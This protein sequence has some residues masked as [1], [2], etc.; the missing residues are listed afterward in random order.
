MAEQRPKNTPSQ[1]SRMPRTANMTISPYQARKIRSHFRFSAKEVKQEAKTIGLTLAQLYAAL[2]LTFTADVKRAKET[3]K[4]MNKYKRQNRL[5]E[6]KFLQSLNV[7]EPTTQRSTT[8]RHA[9]R[10][11]EYYV[12]VSFTELTSYKNKNGNWSQF[13]ESPQAQYIRTVARDS[14]FKQAAID[15]VYRMYD[16]IP[17]SEKLKK[18]KEGSVKIESVR[19]NDINNPVLIQDIPMRRA[20]VLAYDF[21]PKAAD[22][23]LKTTSMECVYD[24]LMHRYGNNKRKVFTKEDMLKDFNRFNKT[25][26]QLDYKDGVTPHMLMEWC[27]K[28]KITCYMFDIKKKMFDNYIS[29]SRNYPPLMFYSVDE[30]MY[31]IEDEETLKSIANRRNQ[32][33]NNTNKH[34]TGTE[35]DEK[36]IEDLSKLKIYDYE[37]ISD[38]FTDKLDTLEAPCIIMVQ[39]CD[40]LGVFKEI[41]RYRN[42]V[43]K[44]IHKGELTIKEIQY[45]HKDGIIRIMKD[46][47][48]GTQMRYNTIMSICKHLNVPWTNQGM[49]SLVQGYYDLFSGRKSLRC[50]IDKEAIAEKCGNKCCACGKKGV[51]FQIDHIVPLAAGGDN[52]NDNLQLLCKPCH[53]EKTKIERDENKYIKI[54]PM[55]STF[56]NQAYDVFNSHLAKQWAYVEK[57]NDYEALQGYDINK[58]RKNIMYYSKHEWPVYTV[59][60]GVKPYDKS[61]LKCGFYFI[62]CHNMFPLRGNGWYPMPQVEYCLNNGVITKDDIK[63]QLIPSLTL[64]ANYFREFIDDVYKKFGNLSKL[65]INAF[66]GCFYRAAYQSVSSLYTRSI[67]YACYA[68]STYN[69]SFAHYMKDLDL[70]Q[71]SY[72]VD[73][74]VHETA[75]PLYLYILGMEACE[76]HKLAEIVGKVSWVKTD[77]VYSENEVDLSKHEWADGV[78]KYKNEKPNDHRVE[79]MA[80]VSRRDKYSLNKTKWNVIKDDDNFDMLAQTVLER[81]C[82]NIDGIA[83]TGKSTLIRKVKNVYDANNIKYI[84]LAPTN[85]AARNIDGMTLHKF[86]GKNCNRLSIIQKRIEFIAAIVIDE[87]SMMHEFFYKILTIMKRIKPSLRIVLVGDFKQL[88]PVKDR[89]NFVYNKSQALYELC[90]GNQ[91][92]LTKCRRADDTLYNMYGKVMS[93]DIMEFGKK[94]TMKHIAWRNETRKKI[95]DICMLAAS[96][97]KHSMLVKKYEFC[98]NSQDMIICVGTPVI[99]R[100]NCREYEICNNDTFT[101]TGFNKNEVYLGDELTVPIEDFSRLFNLAY[102]VTCHKA[103]GDTFTEEYTIHEW[104]YMDERL[105]YVALSRATDINHVNIL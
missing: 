4:I 65:A 83:G 3:K 18:V 63:Y 20:K 70:Y 58:C 51:P 82:C 27:K 54:D 49:G 69:G 45:K 71:I 36:V 81:K 46:A 89:A 40:L 78:P 92:K 101:I 37:D 80:R 88:A 9:D 41:V 104:Q 21:M 99:G 97:G 74:S 12:R 67:D 39:Q 22:V 2:D 17:D 105:R 96:K 11:Q 48:F 43:P 29:P 94:F 13:Y 26:K 86:V 5:E 90:N 32:N 14:T 91:I 33:D 102:C 95:N 35:D 75:S 34:L 87:V 10:R 7:Q 19:S 100:V 42:V 79:N 84:C 31:L 55:A 85:K 59:M 56:S 77:C 24:C 23:S 8:D 57:L 30:H 66:I 103:Q 98:P 64:P 38:D 68:Y 52:S 93:L 76:V 16:D 6:K 25:G 62:E 15:K 47:N 72:T 44:V 50:Y 53:Y 60:D 1:N 61:D 73:F 28:Y